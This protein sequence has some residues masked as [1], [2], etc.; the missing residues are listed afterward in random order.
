MEAIANN[1]VHGTTF[2][3]QNPSNHVSY[4]TRGM[5]GQRGITYVLDNLDALHIEW[6][7]KKDEHLIE[8]S[9]LLGVVHS[10]ANQDEILTDVSSVRRGIDGDAN[11]PLITIESSE[12]DAG[13][14]LVRFND[15]GIS[16]TLNPNHNDHRPS[17]WLEF[18]ENRTV[19]VSSAQNDIN[20]TAAVNENVLM[21][22]DDDFSLELSTNFG[23][24]GLNYV[25]KTMRNTVFIG[26]AVATGGKSEAAQLVFKYLTTAGLV[27]WDANSSTNS[28][29]AANQR[30]Q[31]YVRAVVDINNEA[32]FYLAFG[33]RGITVA[34]GT[35]N[36]MLA[37]FPT[38]DTFIQ[39]EAIN[40]YLRSEMSSF[41]PNNLP[42]G[43]Q[44]PIDLDDFFEFDNL[45]EF[46]REITNNN[47]SNQQV[48]INRTEI[49]NSGGVGQ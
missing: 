2:V 5:R 29:A 16:L 10:I 43:L 4:I 30:V 31:S 48:G 39:I 34:T 14:H 3:F 23:A 8:R 11:G 36:Q 13:G 28:Q 24:A 46:W 6:F 17:V 26:A 32:S 7:V 9:T 35:E 19:F 38:S 25:W 41:D 22:L 42:H 49:K 1:S 40:Q 21:F 12:L 27:S 47:S 33:A 15:V 18:P 45:Y 20:I 44:Y 37:P